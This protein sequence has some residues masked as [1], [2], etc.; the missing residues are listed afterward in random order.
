ML[1]HAREWQSTVFLSLTIDWPVH[2][3]EAFASSL[4]KLLKQSR[5]DFPL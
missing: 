2:E 4:E 3:R 1:Q 5:K